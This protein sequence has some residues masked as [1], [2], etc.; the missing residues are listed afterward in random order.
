MALEFP[1]YQLIFNKIIK[2]FVRVHQIFDVAL[3][4]AGYW[5]RL[6]RG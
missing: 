3:P 6:T 4:E 1:K 2:Q 5:H